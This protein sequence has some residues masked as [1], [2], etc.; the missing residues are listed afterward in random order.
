MTEGVNLNQR[1]KA[2]NRKRKRAD[3]YRPEDDQNETGDHRLFS[4]NIKRKLKNLQ[5]VI[6]LL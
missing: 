1:R 2:Q 6:E 3:S 4:N 5:W